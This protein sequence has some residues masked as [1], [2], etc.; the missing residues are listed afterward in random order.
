MDLSKTVK[1]S[2]HTSEQTNL[3]SLIIG[4]IKHFISKNY[5]FKEFTGTFCRLE[6]YMKIIAENKSAKFYC[7]AHRTKYVSVM[8]YRIMTL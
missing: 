6:F 1:C 5:T 8:S 7:L 2:A 3:S 4:R